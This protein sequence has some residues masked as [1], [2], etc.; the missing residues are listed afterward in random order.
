MA[1]SRL[2]YLLL[3]M[4]VHDWLM[5]ICVVLSS[6]CPPTWRI[7]WLALFGFQYRPH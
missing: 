4:T 1:H 6:I 7:S 5:D 3:H 2:L